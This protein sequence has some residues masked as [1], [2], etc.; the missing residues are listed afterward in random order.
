MIGKKLGISPFS[1]QGKARLDEW[2]RDGKLTPKKT[3]SPVNG[4]RVITY[5]IGEVNVLAAEVQALRDRNTI[6]KDGKDYLHTD[7]VCELLGVKP[8]T[9]YLWGKYGIVPLGGE[10]LDEIRTP[11]PG[12][13]FVWSNG[14]EWIAAKQVERIRAALESRRTSHA[15]GQP[16]PMTD[17]F[18]VEG[19]T[20]LTQS[21]VA[22]GRGLTS[23][24][25]TEVLYRLARD[26]VVRKK[27]VR[28]RTRGGKR[29]PFVYHQPD[30]QDYF[31]AREIAF[32]GVFETE[33][34]PAFSVARAVVELRERWQFTCSRWFLEQQAE[35]SRYLPAGKLPS[36]PREPPS[37]HPGWRGREITS[38]LQL[39]LANM[40]ATI[41]GLVEAGNNLDPDWKDAAD[42][43]RIL[44]YDHIKARRLASL[45]KQWR[46][47]GQLTNVRRI[48][49]GQTRPAQ[50]GLCVLH[51][52]C[53]SLGRGIRAGVG[54]SDTDHARRR[55][56]ALDMR[57]SRCP[58]KLTLS[59]SRRK[60]DSPCWKY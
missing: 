44:G 20:Y 57:T 1:P 55:I 15:A 60:T 17:I 26:N 5:P 28:K 4:K 45:L 11:A 58:G 32:D 34:G 35:K 2:E 29:Y 31:N 39:D 43:A 10:M 40:V 50:T 25:S 23:P 48:L 42:I 52:R 33:E 54:E 24:L 13:G 18:V 30:L 49:V 7:K 36:L 51:P 22:K 59:N 46:E 56:A 21:A 12:N 37:Q 19:E 16:C 3:P 6:R 9:L 41:K 38:I 47:G 27:E 8:Q 14:F 53:D